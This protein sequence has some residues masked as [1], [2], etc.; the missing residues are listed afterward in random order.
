M[1]MM[2]PDF[3]TNFALWAEDLNLPYFNIHH[4]VTKSQT[5]NAR[6]T[7]LIFSSFPSPFTNQQACTTYCF[8]FPKGLEKIIAQSLQVLRFYCLEQT[9]TALKYNTFPK[10]R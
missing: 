1:K 4:M 10:S 5:L 6:N 8:F 2:D 9:N 3:I 7:A